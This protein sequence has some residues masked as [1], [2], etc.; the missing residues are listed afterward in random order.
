MRGAN[1]TRGVSVG[2]AGSDP[3]MASCGRLLGLRR[4]SVLAVAALM[5]GGMVGCGDDDSGRT[6]PRGDD[7]DDNVG[8]QVESMTARGVA[9]ALRVVMEADDLG[10]DQNQRDIDVIQESVDD[11][12]GRPDVTGIE[13]E[14]GDGRDDD[15]FVDVHVNDEVACLSIATNGD[16]D[17]T[18]GAC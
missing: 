5:V 7:P 9:E 17:V 13:D 15:G 10:P 16:I 11:L 18:G 14:D 3:G 1:S 4:W 8:E 6:E 12:P 2:A